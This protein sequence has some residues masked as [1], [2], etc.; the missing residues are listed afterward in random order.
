MLCAALLLIPPPPPHPQVKIARVLGTDEL[1]KYIKK[2]DLELDSHFDGLLTRF[3]AKPWARFITPENAH[4]ATPEAID[5]IDRLL[6]F[7]HVDRLTAK[8]AL[9]HPWLAP[10]REAAAHKA[11]EGSAPV[12]AAPGE[13]AAGPAGAPAAAASTAAS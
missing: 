8:E 12:G 10:V 9:A 3:P 13:G 2:Y 4:L 7:D 5:F 11:A 6:R 1:N